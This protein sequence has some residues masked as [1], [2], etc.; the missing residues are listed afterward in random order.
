MLLSPSMSSILNLP[1]IITIARIA[2]IPV[3]ILLMSADDGALRVASAV[4]FAIAAGSD[5]VD[6]Y[7]ARSRNEVSAFGRMLDPIADKLLVGLLLVA[8]AWDG[9]LSALDL[10]P[11]L[12][13]MFREFFISGLREY[14]GNS[15][16]VLHVSKLAKWKTTL[17]LVAVTLILLEPA[18]PV[19]TL[20]SDV[21]LWIAGIITVWTGIQYFNSAMP[22]FSDE[23]PE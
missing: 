13:I 11:V 5:W 9:S 1:N 4:L 2:T 21:V 17:Q 15:Q 19:L 12:A 14:L 8:L 18:L 22:A 23:Q 10:V 16:V 7:L 6:G 3:I 20:L